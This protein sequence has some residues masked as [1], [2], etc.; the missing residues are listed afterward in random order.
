MGL[1]ISKQHPF[2]TMDIRANEDREGMQAMQRRK[3]RVCDAERERM[4]GWRERKDVV[5]AMVLIE[6]VWT[7]LLMIEQLECKLTTTMAMAIAKQ[8]SRTLLVIAVEGGLAIT[9]TITT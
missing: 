3:G 7:L 2:I 9:I 1:Q 6:T 4:Y 8:Q 5:L